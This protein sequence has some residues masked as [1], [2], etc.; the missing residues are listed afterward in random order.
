MTSVNVSLYI[1]YT[2]YFINIQVLCIFIWAALAIHYKCLVCKE[3]MHCVWV[4]RGSGFRLHSYGT[5]L[6]TPLQPLPR[7][8]L[9]HGYRIAHRKRFH[10]YFYIFRCKIRFFNKKKIPFYHFIQAAWTV[11]SFCLSSRDRLCGRDD[12]WRRKDPNL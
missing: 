9:Q 4:F 11:K 8:C 6:R 3:K 10:K 2:V 1:R 7:F 12:V 5:Y